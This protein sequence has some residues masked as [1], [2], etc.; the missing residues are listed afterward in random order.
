MRWNV[1]SANERSSGYFA[2]P[3]LLLNAA[4]S[5]RNGGRRSLGNPQRPRRLSYIVGLDK[6]EALYER[7]DKATAA[8]LLFPRIDAAADYRLIRQAVRELLGNRFH[9]EMFSLC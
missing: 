7:G 4:S 5:R 8:S 2:R 9:L 6:K 1:L 3:C